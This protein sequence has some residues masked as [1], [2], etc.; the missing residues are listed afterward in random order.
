VVVLFT[1]LIV[2]DLFRV[3]GIN[4][5]SRCWAIWMIR[6]VDHTRS[7]KGEKNCLWENSRA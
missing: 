4:V 7:W 1:H 5:W 3:M 2:S 6:H